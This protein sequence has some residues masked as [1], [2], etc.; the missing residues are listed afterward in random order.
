MLQ[1]G[2]QKFYDEYVNLKI[3]PFTVH[4]T[5]QMV[6]HA[7]THK[8]HINDKGEKH[9]L[10]GEHPESHEWHDDDF[11]PPAVLPSRFIVDRTKH[12]FKDTE[13]LSPF[14]VHSN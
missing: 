11:E 6:G 7:V 3:K 9:G 12:R 5:M 10:Q 2:A 13:P 1:T 8:T 4:H 14:V